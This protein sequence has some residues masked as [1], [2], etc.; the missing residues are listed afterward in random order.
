M[1]KK[2]TRSSLQANAPLLLSQLDLICLFD[3]MTF[4]VLFIDPARRVI[5]INRFLEALTGYN[6]EEVAGVHAVK[7]GLGKPIGSLT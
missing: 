5:A 2:K 7:K 4:G 1:A 6:R 3:S